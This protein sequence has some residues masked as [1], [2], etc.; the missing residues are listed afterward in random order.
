MGFRVGVRGRDCAEGIRGEKI[1]ISTGNRTRN[2]F[3]FPL[4]PILPGYVQQTP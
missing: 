1:V 4:S 3:Y 2:P